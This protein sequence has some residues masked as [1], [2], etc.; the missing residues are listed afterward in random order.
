M[1]TIL[2]VDDDFGF[3]KLLETILTGEG[4]AVETVASVRDACA[5]GERRK[6]HLILSD[7]R[8]P[9]GDG[10]EVVRRFAEQSPETPV[11]MVS[12]SGAV[13]NAVEAMKAG[14]AGYIGKPLSSPDELR[15]LVRKTLDQAQIAQERDLLREEE[16]ARFNCNNLI[17]R[18]PRML[19]LLDTV[20]KVAPTAAT[21]LILGESGT[22]REALARSIHFNSPRAGRAFVTVNCGALSPGLIESELLGHER[23]ASTGAATQHAGRFERAHLG[24]L[25]LDE[26]GEL[27]ANLQIKLL[28]IL[29]EKTFERVGGTRQISVDVRVIAATD[30]DLKRQ[31]ADGRFREDLFYRLNTFPLQ[32]PPL[33]ERR[34]DIPALAR[35]FLSRAAREIR[36][37]ELMLT[38]GAEN[39]LLLYDWPGNVRELE[40]V[41]QRVAILCDRRV[42]ARDLPIGERPDREHPLLW[43]DIERQAIEDALRMNGGNRTRAARQLGISLRTL[44]YR[45]KEWGLNA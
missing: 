7:L 33:R 6:F 18:D 31:V 45:L 22:G 25:F 37:P 9:D 24:T 30:R 26:I 44:Q 21:V 34:S 42:E 27:D 16:G 2:V 11:L 5:A 43:K 35:F 10:L 28:R 19:D 36:K 40:N 32:V 4:Y 1:E 12:A 41:M 20:R 13:G 38:Q 17:A 8:L 39:A 14:A 29:Q 15:V 23:G 3:R